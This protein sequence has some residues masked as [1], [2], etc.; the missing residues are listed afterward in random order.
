MS[1]ATLD[2]LS[3]RFDQLEPPDQSKAV[4][5]IEELSRRFDEMEPPAAPAV[6]K[7][8][9]ANEM[10]RIPSAFV[11][12]PPRP[13]EQAQTWP[14]HF[15]PNIEALTGGEEIGYEPSP[16][17]ANPQS[18]VR[19]GEEQRLFATGRTG[20]ELYPGPGNVPQ[21]EAGTSADVV[22]GP[23][24]RE[25][26]PPNI[27]PET[28]Q[29]Q[30]ALGPMRL[31][32]KPEYEGV[33]VAPEPAEPGYEVPP[34][35][36]SPAAGTRPYYEPVQ[37]AVTATGELL[38][39][40]V[41]LGI[42][43]IHIAANLR[44]HLRGD[45]VGGS[46]DSI[47]GS[48]AMS[49]AQDVEVWLRNKSREWQEHPVLGISPGKDWL[50]E[51]DAMEFLKQLPGELGGFAPWVLGGGL[52]KAALPI[53]A[54]LAGYPGAK[55]AVDQLHLPEEQRIAGAMGIATIQGILFSEA[56]GKLLPTPAL[57]LKARQAAQS[58]FRELMIRGGY[59][60]E[61][62]A[63]RSVAISLL[64]VAQ[65]APITA[66]NEYAKRETERRWM[67]IADEGLDTFLR[68]LPTMTVAALPA[69]LAGGLR[70]GAVER[71]MWEKGQRDVLG[72]SEWEEMTGAKERLPYTPPVTRIQAPPGIEPGAVEGA[73]PTTPG[74]I[75]A[76]RASTEAKPT[77]PKPVA[78]KL[79]PVMPATPVQAAP[80]AIAGEV[81]GPAPTAE[82]KPAEAPSMDVM[83]LEARKWRGAAFAADA[84]YGNDNKAR[85]RHSEMTT[86]GDLDAYLM[87]KF[88][89]DATTARDVSNELT[90]KN[91]KPIDTPIGDYAGQPWADAALA[92]MQ[93]PAEAAKPIEAPRTNVELA[94]EAKARVEQAPSLAVVPE[95]APPEEAPT[96]RVEMPPSP[97]VKPVVR[98]AY[99]PTTDISLDPE[100]FQ[101]KV[102]YG[103]GGVAEGGLRDVHVWDPKRAG[104]LAIWR[105]PANNKLYVINGHSRY[106]L[107]KRTGTAEVP[108]FL[109]D[110]PTAKDARIDGAIINISE[111]RGT[112]LDAAKFFR[113]TSFTKEDL[114]KQGLSLREGMVNKGLAIANLSDKLFS[115]YLHGELEEGYAVIIGESLKSSAHQDQAY[116][117]IQK[118]AGGKRPVSQ[119]QLK[120]RIRLIK[121]TGAVSETTKSLFGDETVE[122]QYLDEK[123]ELSNRIQRE[124]K[125]QKAFK[126]L[127]TRAN[128]NR[129]AELGADF[130]VQEAARRGQQGAVLE[131]MYRNATERKGAVSDAL[132]QAA[133]KLAEGGDENVIYKEFRDQV[134]K[135]LSEIESGGKVSG[136]RQPEAI[137]AGGEGLFGAEAKPATGEVAAPGKLERAAK[138]AGDI[139]KDAADR[140]AKRHGPE[141]L[142][143]GVDPLDL[144]DMVVWTLA[145]SAQGVLKFADLVKQATE[146]FTMM[147][148]GLLRRILRSVWTRTAAERKQILAA[149]DQTAKDA[150]AVK[151]ATAPPQTPAQ[152]ELDAAQIRGSSSIKDARAK[153]KKVMDAFSV[154]AAIKSEIAGRATG[155][156]GSM[157]QQ[158]KSKMLADWATQVLPEGISNQAVRQITGAR[159]PSEMIRVVGAVHQYAE[160][161]ARREAYRQLL[162]ISKSPLLNNI[163]Q[164][165]ADRVRLVLGGL[166]FR[167]GKI[168]EATTPL[169]FVAAVKE[170][171]RSIGLTKGEI[172]KLGAQDEIARFDSAIAQMGDEPL[173]LQ[174]P[175]N[176]RLMGSYLRF[177]LSQNAQ[178]M[179]EASAVEKARVEKLHGTIIGESEA[180]NPN[181]PVIAPGGRQEPGP[182]PGSLL[183]T[184]GR[185]WKSAQSIIQRLSGA[186]STLERIVLSA[187]SKANNSIAAFINPHARE[188]MDLFVRHGLDPQTFLGKSEIAPALGSVG[189]LRAKARGR[190]SGVEVFDVP[191]PGAIAVATGAP[192]KSQQMTSIERVALIG[193]LKDPQALRNMLSKGFEG[194]TFGNDA[195]RIERRIRPTVQ[196]LIAIYESST[197]MER[198]LA[199][200]MFGHYNGD[201]KATMNEANVINKGYELTQRDNY[202]PI[203]IDSAAKPKVPSDP[204]NASAQYMFDQAGPF[205]PREEK[206]IGPYR[207]RDALEVFFQHSMYVGN[208]R[209]KQQPAIEAFRAIGGPR[210]LGDPKVVAALSRVPG[211]PG[212]LA[213]LRKLV[214]MEITPE[215]SLSELGWI[216]R[217]VTKFM[218]GAHKSILLANIRAMLYQPVSVFRALVYMDADSVGK[219]IR[220]NLLPNKE[221]DATRSAETKKYNP[222]LHRRQQFGTL[223]TSTPE[224]Q[225]SSIYQLIWGEHP[226]MKEGV[227]ARL[228]T[229]GDHKA[230][231]I[232]I[233]AAKYQ[234]A[235]E[236]LTGEAAMNR[237]YAFAEDVVTRTQVGSELGAMSGFSLY[238][239]EHPLASPAIAF[240][241]E[242]S[243]LNNLIYQRILTHRQAVMNAKSPG[244]AAKAH[245][246]LAKD[247]AILVL[248]ESTMI[249][250]IQQGTG[251]ALG[252]F[253]GRKRDKD[254]ADH[255]MGWLLNAVGNIQGGPIL[256]GALQAF[257]AAYR[258]QPQWSSTGNLAYDMIQDGIQG[259]VAG[260]KAMGDVLTGARFDKG[261][262][263][264]QRKAFTSL[265]NAADKII[266]PLGVATGIPIPGFWR[267]GRTFVPKPDETKWHYPR[268]M[269]AALKGDDTRIEKE[270]RILYGMG[271]TWSNVYSSM[272]ARK[273]PQA[274]QDRVSAIDDKIKGRNPNR[275]VGVPVYAD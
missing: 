42:D 179:S 119:E 2:E 51:R 80:G 233:D 155:D 266:M 164:K 240:T 239:R 59:S 127:A 150:L 110:S 62:M 252:G 269:T 219:A 177:V 138:T 38:P 206:S 275:P 251:Y 159:T 78:E 210:T 225:R 220:D 116:A 86:K 262:M 23:A 228:F 182:Q 156:K 103:E 231:N 249:Y 16:I 55:E 187:F 41:K 28:M 203:E 117:L 76:E 136:A 31:T 53:M 149:P 154:Q 106:D 260:A 198:E 39:G 77:E 137:P 40:T 223:G 152:F 214:A 199:D 74:A 121:A 37:R 109:L 129:L 20:Q 250:A 134:L 90:H 178:R 168:N 197:P 24:F 83:V 94:K 120:E 242:V 143:M 162:G 1:I 27:Q 89:V 184:L 191:T 69:S 65:G 274:A 25:Y 204:L 235:K 118:A 272:K 35:A 194:L 234:A 258:G 71:A 190:P 107:A 68:T 99:T 140:I 227:L 21:T 18:S 100:R 169:T 273:L 93:Q 139:A 205:H 207:V 263:K 75:Q 111:G 236:G 73:A 32:P 189:K 70:R 132:E 229:S 200:R 153:A 148:P 221:R 243:K 146:H 217:A 151:L 96:V 176:L 56:I 46:W 5:S 58:A 268:I 30:P 166:R 26:A 218:S 230:I 81:Q 135:G 17:V 102:G 48:A 85:L 216:D 130:D 142:H 185:P 183:P 66:V 44:D 224:L 270:L 253:W 175:G 232:I 170:I 188:F 88:G 133:R 196:S 212:D 91:L 60:V 105:D 254:A 171:A 259:T 160:F 7:G 45:R 241:N 172:E 115:M 147:E 15:H 63:K 163:P 29:V 14:E 264:D 193:M 6:A 33:Q 124:F 79:P 215:R 11:P 267:L 158:A 98:L 246:V 195:G 141:T 255:A 211:G 114:A 181:P 101:Y 52:S 13:E 49:G 238:A 34:V 165:A 8:K 265:T 9:I 92:K 67:N 3:K 237:A 82:A 95:T 22:T 10:V 43:A 161:Y 201:V 256:T 222:F 19:P 208:Y 213:R 271:A 209:W 84:V 64:M 54:G 192:V 125:S 244:D 128:V 72:L 131:W 112:V 257:Y 87:S 157:V 50:K 104:V 180:F 145:K 113:D 173:G 186:K 36:V 247:L 245:G 126:E 47:R 202:W 57:K 144:K 261:P 61:E 97:E 122:R 108:T 174:A 4:P 12:Q 167:Q 226:M 123:V 248:F